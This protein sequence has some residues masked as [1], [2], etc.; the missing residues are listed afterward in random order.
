VTS[1]CLLWAGG[2]SDSAELLI[3]LKSCSQLSKDEISPTT[4]AK[5]NRMQWQQERDWSETNAILVT[6]SSLSSHE[7]TLRNAP[8]VDQH[9]KA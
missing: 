3:R 7:K 6:P 1:D 5:N 4:C 8:F 2:F 9:A